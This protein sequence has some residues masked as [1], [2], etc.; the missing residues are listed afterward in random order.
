MMLGAK[1]ALSSDHVYPLADHCLWLG[2]HVVAA[3]SWVFVY[4]GTGINLVTT[5][6]NTMQPVQ[7]IYWQKP[8]VVLANPDVL[9]FLV[10]AGNLQIGNKPNKTI[11]DIWAAAQQIQL[12][13]DN[14]AKLSE[15]MQKG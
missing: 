14:V 5:E 10:T 7:A 11:S 2:E 15:G 8:S 6:S 9:P 12:P 3:N 4:T 1:V 13:G